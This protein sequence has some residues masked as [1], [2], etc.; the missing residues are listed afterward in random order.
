MIIALG[1]L[2]LAVSTR[3]LQP[4]TKIE[5]AALTHPSRVEAGP[6]A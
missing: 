2:A 4:P 1:A 3:R 5:L 6:A